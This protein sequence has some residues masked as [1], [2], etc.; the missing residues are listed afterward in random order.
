MF[1]TGSSDHMSD[2]YLSIKRASM[3]TLVLGACLLLSPPTLTAKEKLPARHINNFILQD[4]SGKTYSLSQY[5]D[6][7]VVVVIFLGT[8]CPLAKLYT[9][10]LEK[11]SQTFKNQGVVILGVMSNQHDSIKNIAEYVEKHK[12]SFPMLKDHKNRVA[13]QFLAKRTPEVYVLD[14]KRNIRYQGRIDDQFGVG[15]I[16]NEPRSR[17]LKNAIEDLLANRPVSV[18]RTEAVGCIIGREVISKPANQVTFSNQ[19]SRLFQKRCVSCHREGQAAPFA[20]TEYDEAVGWAGMIQE[21]VQQKRMPPWHADEKFGQFKNDCHLSESEKQLIDD[22]VDAGAPQGDPAMLPEPLKFASEWQLPR[23]PDV[24]YKINKTPFVVPADEEIRYQYYTVDPGFTEDKWVCAAE[25]RP[26]NYLVVHHVLVFTRPKTGKRKRSI[27]ETS[28]F[29]AAYVPG[30]LPQPLKPGMAKKLPANSELIF[31]VHYTSVGSKQT[32]VSELGLIFTDAE[33]VTHQ[34]VTSSATNR[35]FV[36]PAH[37]TNHEVTASSPRSE[38]PVQLLTMM[39][40]LHLRGKSFRYETL[41][42]DGKKETI[43]SIPSYDFNWQT[44]YQ[45]KEPLTLAPGTRIF[46]TAHYDNSKQ[47]PFNPNPNIPVRWG[48]QTWDEM[49]IGYFDVA[50]PLH[51]ET[52]VEVAKALGGQPEKLLARI[53]S[54]ADGEITRDEIS[55]QQLPIFLLIDTNKNDRVSLKE[56]REAIEKYRKK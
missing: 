26:G 7:K 12:I 34:V 46:C 32:D 24:V 25:V 39:P 43:L 33:S 9:V 30:L 35:R 5:R 6:K 48:D 27:D 55:K 1:Q 31:Q 38:T 16:R 4:S 50:I 8:E 13:D 18:P 44:A 36:I 52:G 41:S 3:F 28:G 23:K 42:P 10:R 54:N 49:M 45:L 2:V 21:V 51:P 22:W 56:L 19:I 47:N 11:M 40:H 53:D 37:A 15:S 17:D 29:L 20:L 14:E